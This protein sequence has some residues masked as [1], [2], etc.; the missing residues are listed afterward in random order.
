MPIGSLCRACGAKLSGNVGWCGRCLTPVTAFAARPPLHEEGSFVG[1]LRRD[2]QMSRWRAGPTTMGPL[3]RVA[4]TIVLL[5]LFPWWALILPMRSIWRKTRVPDDA[6]PTSLD[7]FRERH[8]V[9]GRPVQ[10]TPVVRISALV[11]VVAAAAAVWFTED[12]IGR[13]GWVTV[14]LVAGGSFALAKEHDL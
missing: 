11:V 10:M 6:P 7:R 8:P 1:T 12:T 4:A 2:V 14:M 9:L 5:L 3:G 13:L